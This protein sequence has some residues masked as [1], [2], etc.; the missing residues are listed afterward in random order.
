MEKSRIYILIAGVILAFGL[1]LVVLFPEAGNW[2]LLPL[3]LAA[4]FILLARRN[5]RKLK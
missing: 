1:L 3:I 5:D 4:V 2:T